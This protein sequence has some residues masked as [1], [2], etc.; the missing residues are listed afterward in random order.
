MDIMAFYHCSNAC[1]VPDNLPVSTVPEIISMACNPVH[2]NTVSE[3]DSLH[4]ECAFG[5]AETIDIHIKW[6]K[7]L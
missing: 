4:Q 1:S 7:L 2:D 5:H 3:V 6:T